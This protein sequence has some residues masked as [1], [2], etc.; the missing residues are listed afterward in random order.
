M[1]AKKT[2]QVTCSL[3][4]R[5]DQGVVDPLEITDEQQQNLVSLN[6]SSMLTELNRAIL[7]FGH[8]TLRHP[9]GRTMSIGGSTG[10]ICRMILDAPDP[11]ELQDFIAELQL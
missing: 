10:G 7:A 2:Y 9:D 3:Q 8:G 11:Q 5:S 6:N 4:R 1:V